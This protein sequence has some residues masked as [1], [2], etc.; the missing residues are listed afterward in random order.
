MASML[1]EVKSTADLLPLSD[2]AE[3][4]LHLLH[5]LEPTEEVAQAEWHALAQSRLAEVRS[6]H[7][8]GIPAERVL[9]SMRRPQ[10]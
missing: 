2:R 4:V 10:S 9:E 3:L 7:V 8:V 6:G 5:T 1:E